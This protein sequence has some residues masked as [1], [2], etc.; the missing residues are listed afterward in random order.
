MHG[1]TK[2]RMAGIDMPSPWWV[3]VTASLNG[4]F[5]QASALQFASE[6]DAQSH[7]VDGTKGE[8]LA[9]PF[10]NGADADKW[11]TAYFKSHPL[12]PP[13]IYN[14]ST[15]AGASSGNPITSSGA[16]GNQIATGLAGFSGFAGIDNFL[17][18]LMDANTW[19]RV[20]EGVLGVILIGVALGKITGADNVI[21]K[22]VNKIP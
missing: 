14:P 3:I 10:T 4:K 2:K 21:T 9:G 17:G 19:L 5:A 13:G 22:A 12:A 11:A 6:S 1:I 18:A 16:L 15:N 20:A 7:T 8:V